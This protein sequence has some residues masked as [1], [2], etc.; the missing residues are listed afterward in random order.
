MLKKGLWLL[1]LGTYGS[2]CPKASE[3]KISVF[4]GKGSAFAT[5]TVGLTKKGGWRDESVL[6]RLIDTKVG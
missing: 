2:L 6:D 3:D 1:E 4:R 5:C